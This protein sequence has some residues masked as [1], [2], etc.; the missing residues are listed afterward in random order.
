MLLHGNG[1]AHCAIRVHQFLA[2]RSVPFRNHPPHSPDLAP[3]DFF[4][5][6]RLKSIRKGARFAV[7]AA[8]QERVTAVLLS[9]PKEPFAD[10]FQ[11]LYD[12]SQK[13]VVKNGD[14]FEGQEI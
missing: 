11:K 1:P 3:A 10:S 4:L 7:M 9:I 2:Q 12:R 8:I 14:Y 13:C 6:P 5:F